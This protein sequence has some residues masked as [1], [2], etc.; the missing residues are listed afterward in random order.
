MRFSGTRLKSERGERT[1]INMVTGQP[2]LGDED[3]PV[4]I[5]VHIANC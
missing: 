4:F 3:T 5:I 1:G 2:S